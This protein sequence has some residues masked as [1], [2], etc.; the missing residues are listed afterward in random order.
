MLVVGAY[1]ADVLFWRVH[2]TV[3]PSVL[4]LGIALCLDWCLRHPR[5]A[6]GRLLDWRPLVAIGV[7]SY[8][9]Y[10]WQELFLNRHATS[11]LQRF[12]LNIA[13]SA[14]VAAA[15]YFLVERPSLSLRARIERRLFARQVP[16][17]GVGA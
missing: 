7:G 6:L 11:P 13:C 5:G 8:W 1:A 9:L 17:A 14:V 2:L 10:L 15:S 3:G 16:A 12:P 4:N